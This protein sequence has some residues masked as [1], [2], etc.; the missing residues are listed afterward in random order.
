MY[1]GNTVLHAAY[2]DK[3]WELFNFLIQKNSNI[4]QQNK[5][6][7]TVLHLTIS[8]RNSTIFNLLMGQN[9]DL[10]VVDKE[11]K[12]YL[13]LALC[14]F[15]KGILPV[16]VSAWP[17]EVRSERTGA[18]WL[19]HCAA[20]DLV[21]GAGVLVEHHHQVG[22]RDTKQQTPLH[23]AVANN[24][25]EYEYQQI[26]GIFIAAH[27]TVSWI[28]SKSFKYWIVNGKKIYLFI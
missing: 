26:I 24:K 6:G 14:H 8:D 17:D 11:G 2:M 4:D 18:S 1:S 5:E 7:K 12:S 19:H 16:L 21:A 3:N 15:D 23:V 9:P 20:R 13:E 27:C 28:L 22:A 25:V 10:K